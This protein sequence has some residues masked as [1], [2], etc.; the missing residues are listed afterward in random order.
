MKDKVLAI[1]ILLCI[2]LFGICF[3]QSKLSENRDI[4]KYS[5]GLEAYKNSDYHTAYRY[6]S[7]VSM[8]SDIKTPALFRQARCAALLGDVRAAKRHYSMILFMYPNSQLFVVS[9]YNLAMLLYELGDYGAR[10]HFVHIIKYY[11]ET[12]FALASEYYVA[13]IDMVEAGKSKFYRRRTNLK[14]KALNHFIRYVKLSPDGR[15]TQESINKI[16]KLG[17]AITDEDSLA[18]AKSYFMRGLY[19]NAAL[20]FNEAP[21]ELA[22]AKFAKNEFKRGNYPLAKT[23]VENGLKHHSYTVDRHDAYDAIDEY[24]KLNNEKLPVINYLLS[25]YSNSN[26]VDY[27]LYLKAKYS[28]DTQKD[29]VYEQLFDKYPDSDFSAEALY[30]VFYSQIDKENFDKAIKLGQKHISHFKKSDTSPAVLFWMGKIYERKHNSI[31]AKSYYKSVMSKYPDSYYS[32]RAY[33][34]LHKDK[35]LFI[36]ANVKT[37]PV[38][39]PCLDKTEQN[40][41]TKLVKLGD[42]DFVSELYKNDDFVQS[43][44]AYRQGKVVH[45]ILLAQKAMKELYPKPK[46]DDVRWRLV[47][48]LNYFYLAEKYKGNQ[49]PLMLL[50]IIREESHFNPGIKSSA[51]A[52]GLMQLMP[53]TADE[54]AR[55]YGVSNNLLN[56][57]ANIRLGSLYY[58]KMKEYLFNRDIYAIMA[59]NGGRSSVER[60]IKRLKYRDIDDFVEKIPYPETQM[61][62]KKVFK[63]YWNYSNI[64]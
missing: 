47:Y 40:M 64:Y 39:F 1:I 45:S 38:L 4:E 52:V 22:W 18:L 7:K 30:K 53:A 8:F 48:P 2:S 46:Y 19:Y 29:T 57:E 21:I 28:D 34:K 41:A 12:D 56:P 37:K 24:L 27:L 59:Y 54:I 15:F 49:D 17:I 44:I 51:G 36:D 14:H 35:E 20:Y 16:A 13:S 25:H 62:V 32:Y 33:C 6:F 9:E 10:K 55:V 43:W 58:S 11:P 50:S 31:L 5:R 23:L 42:Y 26:C 60:W 3:V 63:S 61:Y